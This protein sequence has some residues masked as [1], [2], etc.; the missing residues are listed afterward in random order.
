[1]LCMCFHNVPGFYVHAIHHSLCL[2]MVYFYTVLCKCN[3][4]VC[5]REQMPKTCQHVI[6]GQHIYVVY[7]PIGWFSK[8]PFTNDVMFFFHN[9]VLVE[10]CICTIL[11]M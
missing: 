10:L 8:I 3:A 2:C 9:H 5:R 7:F 1:M 6:K 11:V 4:F